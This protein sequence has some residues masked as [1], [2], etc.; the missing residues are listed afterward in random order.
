MADL[1][2]VLGALV[3]LCSAALYP[4][5]G[6]GCVAG[7][8]IKIYSGWPVPQTLN[9]DIAA[10]RAHVSVYPRGEERN[11]TRFPKTSQTLALNP[12]TITLDV[13]NNTITVGGVVST[14]Q[15]CVVVVGNNQ[16]AYTYP[17]LNTDTINSV[18]IGIAASIPGATSL[19]GVVTVPGATLLKAQI[20]VPGLSITEI[21]RQDRLFQISVWAPTPESRT[22]IAKVIDPYLT[23]IERF[24]LPDQSSARIIYK[25]SPITDG[26]EKSAIY[27][28]DFLYSVEY[29]TTKIETDY[30]I[31]ANIVGITTTVNPI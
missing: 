8:P 2:D 13:L 25:G 26:I 17:I 23:D 31:S 15:I 29:A 16:N 27:R 5:P 30:V 28:R 14:P 3:K 21:R 6:E 19:N 22:A 9:A 1:D 12:V 10:N 7:L 24:T 18:A 11:T 20:S 4:V